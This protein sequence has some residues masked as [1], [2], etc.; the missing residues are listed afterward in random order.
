LL[1]YCVDLLQNKA[2]EKRQ[3][4]I[5]NSHPVVIMAN[6]EKLWRVASNLIANA[7]KF[8][9][10]GEQI[11]VLLE[12]N[13]N[14]VCVSVSDR[15]IGIPEHLRSKIFDMV[16]EAKRPGTQGEQPFG[17]GL[18]ISKHIVEAHGGRIWFESNVARGKGTT[19]FVELPR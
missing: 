16:T 10:P 11:D 14:H 15:G 17:L 6:R 4:I 13:P 9:P 1:R 18:A 8:S 7:V 3:N 5:L 2:R 12:V 19:F